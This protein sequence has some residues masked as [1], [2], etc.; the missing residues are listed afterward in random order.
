VSRLSGLATE[1]RG[2]TVLARLSGEL[3]IAEASRTGQRIVEAVPP[4]ASAVVIDLTELKLIDS[5][6]VATLFSLARQFDVRRQEVRV[7]ASPGGLVA[8]VL[9][10]VDFRR[11]APVD[12]DLQEALAQLSA[13][14]P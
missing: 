1:E 12:H 3:D 11:A 5:S 2:S 10:I 7:V 14:E 9:E 13:V 4:S 8:R 6:G